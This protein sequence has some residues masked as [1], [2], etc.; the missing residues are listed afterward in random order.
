MNLITSKGREVRPAAKVIIR[1]ES[2]NV[3]FVESRKSCRYNLPGGGID[4]GEN[5]DTAALRELHEEIGIKK[6][7]LTDFVLRTT[8]SGPVATGRGELMLHWTVFE[9]GLAVPADELVIPIGSEIKDIHCLNPEVFAAYG[10]KSVLA[11]QALVKTGY[12]PE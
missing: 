12:L 8:V 10:N 6:A 4:R 1:D 5:P 9:A 11:H 3:I 7:Q 2:N